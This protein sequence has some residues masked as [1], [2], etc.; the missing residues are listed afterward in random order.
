MPD[1]P[2]PIV[3]IGSH[4][5]SLFVRVDAVPREGE[6]VLG[7]DYDEPADGGKASNQAV[8]AAKLGA[9]VRLVTVVGRDE[10]GSRA[11][12]LFRAYGI[13]TRWVAEQDDR[14]DIGF[15]MLPPSRIP[16]IVTAV[17]CSAALT[18]DFVD[19]AASAV[20]GASWVLCQLEAPP[21]CALA[22]F[23]LARARGART[24]LNP[25]PPVALDPELA[26]LTDVLVP[27]EH[28]AAALLGGPD[29]PDNL[30]LALRSRTGIPVV[31]V[32]AGE[33]GAWIAS[34]K[35]VSHVPALAVRSEDTT[36]AGDA[37]IG[38][39]AFAFRDGR[40]IPDAVAF[41]C[42][43]AG[44][45]VSRPGTMPAFPT[46]EELREAEAA[47]EQGPLAPNS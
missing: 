27:N 13:D 20:D 42:M 31:I 17:G 40:D 44:V 9:P 16:A 29:D 26:V 10:F 8:A 38:A 6:T 5:Q 12:Q 2:G 11:L 46:I 18:A 21:E 25:A 36:G 33:G 15:V 34:A 30:A 43:A 19:R 41:A 22:S 47:R 32:T 4:V 1:E 35:G 28:E 37:F 14:T 23:R 7:F 24:I 3:V 45:S 39:L